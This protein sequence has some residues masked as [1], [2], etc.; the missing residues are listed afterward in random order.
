MDIMPLSEQA[1]GFKFGR[2]RHFKGGEYEAI[3]LA[4]HSE[5]GEEM[6]VYRHGADDRALWVRPL[7]MFLEEIDREGKRESRFA[8]LGPSEERP[9][10]SGISLEDRDE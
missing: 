1:L 8:Y 10:G 6:V 3:A 5:T 2:Y 7:T 9:T 4:R